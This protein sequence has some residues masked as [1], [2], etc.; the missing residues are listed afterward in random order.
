MVGKGVSIQ[1]LIGVGLELVGGVVVFWDP[2]S[3]GGS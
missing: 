1:A 2:H 3:L